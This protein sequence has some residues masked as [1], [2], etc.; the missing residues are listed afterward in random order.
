LRGAVAMIVKVC[1]V[2]RRGKAGEQRV[3]LRRRIE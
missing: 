1:S 3:P 2:R